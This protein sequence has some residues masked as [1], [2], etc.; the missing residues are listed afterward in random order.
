MANTYAIA[1]N[2]PTTTVALSSRTLYTATISINGIPCPALPENFFT[3]WM[4][5]DDL[6]GSGPYLT[7]TLIFNLIGTHTLR[8]FLMEEVEVGIET[9]EVQRA[10]S[11]PYTITV[12][13]TTT[14]YNVKDS[15]GKF[16][17]LLEL[18]NSASSTWLPY[19]ANSSNVFPANYK[20]NMD[21]HEYAVDTILRKSKLKI[22]DADKYP[23]VKTFDISYYPE[24]NKRSPI[25][26]PGGCPTWNSKKFEFKPYLTINGTNYRCYYKIQKTTNNII[27]T[28]AYYQDSKWKDATATSLTAASFSGG[29]LPSRLLILLQ[30]AG[31]AGGGY[32]CKSTS[33][34]YCYNSE[35]GLYWLIGGS[36]G[37][38]LPAILDFDR[39]SEYY[40]KVGTGGRGSYPMSQ[41]VWGHWNQIKGTSEED[42]VR[43]QYFGESGEVT[44]IST[45]IRD[46]A[47]SIDLRKNHSSI[48]FTGMVIAAAGGS[49]TGVSGKTENNSD[50]EGVTVS[51]INTSKD[52]PKIYRNVNCGNYNLTYNP[53]NKNVK[54]RV[55]YRINDFYNSTSNFPYYAIGD[56]EHPDKT[57]KM[58]D[59][60]VGP[61]MTY[62]GQSGGPVH[63]DT[64]SLNYGIHGNVD[65]SI[66]GTSPYFSDNI[67]AIDLNQMNYNG[68]SEKTPN[69]VTSLYPK[70]YMCDKLNLNYN[71][72][73]CCVYDSTYVVGGAPS[74]L[75]NGG[76]WC[77][78]GSGIYIANLNYSYN[79][80][81]T[82]YGDLSTE[83]IK[84]ECIVEAE[85]T[86]GGGGYCWSR[87]RFGFMMPYAGFPKNSDNFEFKSGPGGSGIAYMYY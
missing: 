12:N 42:S 3:E 71:P 46:M 74:C 56:Q 47:T 78:I 4:I 1:L 10:V 48:S 8:V 85:R 27:I 67:P 86:L 50:T 53:D 35:H 25:I 60:K 33:K 37:G 40:L 63:L 24:I 5:D 2:E 68:S 17:D 36:S 52:N 83:N 39:K 81:S 38:T 87:A 11:P 55:K 21:S 26:E 66:M 76:S 84:Q 73:R 15:T 32:V 69:Y 57:W 43:G 80:D 23:F 22:I 62:S 44:F 14:N 19:W 18:Q 54:F 7:N 49:G 65:V 79:Y 41:Y 28:P 13:P 77:H 64:F 31:A 70:A 58:L 34:Q 59:S 51:V 82:G 75:G 29:I 61:A 6:K 45:D 30:G 72:G 20:R 9:E 16:I